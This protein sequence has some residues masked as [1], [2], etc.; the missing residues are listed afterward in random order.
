MEK[1]VSTEI[2][3]NTLAKSDIHELWIGDYFSDENKNFY[4]KAFAYLHKELNIPAGAHILDVGCGSGTHSITLARMGFYVTGIDYSEHVLD[5]AKTNVEKAGL[6]DKITLMHNNILQLVNLPEF[7]YVL[8]WGVLMHIPEYEKA[9]VQLSNHVK[10][11]GTLIISEVNMQSLESRLQRFLNTI[12]GKKN[13]FSKKE[14]GVEQWWDSP[15]GKIIVRHINVSWLQKFYK[16]QNLQFIK[17]IPGQFTESYTVISNKL[18]L[19]LI[20]GINSIMF[21]YI[22]LPSYSFGNILVFK[23]NKN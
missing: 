23:K 3:E 13:H 2:V 22:K 12:R 5:I 20:Y 1:F 19:K 15:S 6:Q 9:L 7:D 17:R 18:L 10:P 11:G 21:G 4:L 8:C 14:Y 16:K